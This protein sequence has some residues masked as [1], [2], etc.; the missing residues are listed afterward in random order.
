MSNHTSS[1]TPIGRRLTTERTVVFVVGLI[2]L[3]AGIAGLLA[4]LGV[5]GPRRSS[6]PVLDPV[7]RQWWL[8]GSAIANTAL[9]V[10]GLV[11]LCLGLWW[12]AR[13]L[14]PEPHP[15]LRLESVGPGSLTVASRAL[16]SAV[17]TDAETVTGVERARVRMG[18]DEQQP[19]LRMTLSLREGTDVR[20]VWEE[21]D[22]RVLSRVR[23]ALGR[24]TVPT[25]IHLRLNRAPRQRVR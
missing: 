2:A 10:A 15:D 24:E 19:A 5:F 13:A 7:V 25:A 17:R 4:S 3:L 12:L 23:Q 11:L 6:S 8:G 1:A 14:R 21:V 9:I 18:G 20:Q 16:T 22:Q